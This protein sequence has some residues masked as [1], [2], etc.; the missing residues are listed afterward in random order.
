M[1]NRIFYAVQQ[2][3]IKPNGSAAAFVAAHGVQSIGI[4]TS[5]NL[6]QV[7]EL[8]QISIYE[9]IENLPEIEVTC[10]KVI[11]GYPPLYMLA[12][13]GALSATLA[14]RSDRR[15]IWALSIF[16][17]TQD[18]A[19]GTPV[20][21]VIM[22]GLYVGSLSYTFPVE[23]NFTESI[24]MTGNDK[25]WNQSSPFQASGQFDNN[26]QPLALTYAS[27]GV[28]RRENLH[29]GVNISGPFTADANGTVDGYETTLLPQEIDGISS[30]GT[31]DKVNGVFN[32][33]VQNI[34]VSTDLG[35]TDL[36]ELGSRNPYHKYAN[37]PTEVTCEIE[38]TSTQGDLISATEEGTISGGGGE[39]PTGTNLANQTIKIK[40][41]EGL[42]LDLGT[43]NKLSNVSYGGGD[44]GGGNVTVTYS[45]SNF[46][47]L[48]VTHPQDPSAL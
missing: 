30:S 24:T 46:N 4:T 6:E 10:E 45:Y 23:G 33:H 44:A 47:D 22:S 35:R 36:L 15:S 41:C 26:D 38:T 11:D 21:E 29:F 48:T 17:D 32:A 7:F 18:A 31:N 20:S 39:C 16:G 8:G 43:R 27:G 13:E 2:V 28:N 25:L 12:T 42:F 5:F 1:S 19:S 3:A 37:F 9:N 40:A 34:T 14:G